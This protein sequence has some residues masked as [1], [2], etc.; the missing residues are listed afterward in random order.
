MPS[1]VGLVARRRAEGAS[2]KGLGLVEMIVAITLLSIA[3]IGTA[4]EIAAYVKQQVV[5][6]SQAVA[7]HLADSWFAYE[8]S[9]TRPSPTLSEAPGAAS[10]GGATTANTSFAGIINPPLNTTP[11]VNGVTYTETWSYHLCPKSVIAGGSFSLAS[12]TSAGTPGPTDTVYGTL[13]ITWNIGNQ[14]HKLTMTRNLADNSIYVPPPTNTTGDSP[15]ANCTRA[16]SITG[17]PTLGSLPKTSNTWGSG[18][19]WTANPGR[20][21]LDSSNH[22]MSFTNS[23]GVQKFIDATTAVVDGGSG[24]AFI[25]FNL[26][27]TG[28]QNTT[29]SGATPP[30]NWGSP[31]CIPLVWTDTTGTHQVDLHLT[32]SSGCV[33]GNACAYT[34]NVPLKSITQTTASPSWD[35]EVT[36]YALFNGTTV[37]NSTSSVSYPFK[38]DSL[39]T[40]TSCNVQGVGSFLGATFGINSFRV[41]QT[42][43]WT[44]AGTNMASSTTVAL[45]NGT[46]LDVTYTQT[47]GSQATFTLIATNDTTS[48]TVTAPNASA[49][50]KSQAGDSI[51]PKPKSAAGVNVAGI[52]LGGFAN[53]VTYTATRNDGKFATCG[54]K[55]VTVIS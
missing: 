51:N 25:T 49:Y 9:Q 50:T 22:P 35:N 23:L 31:S 21:D 13:T 39:P 30:A 14:G 26:T 32:S 28:L 1:L 11:K 29:Y 16:G 7:N 33:P 10:N 48:W 12:C 18:A 40:L 27:E 42:S 44:G 34:G 38:V 17:T 45:N 36:F 8:E 53:T 3:L 2:E 46:K 37:A 6:N 54:P 20:V 47:N 15:L 24:G 41:P 52:V 5:E 43:S 19:T 55:T 4:G